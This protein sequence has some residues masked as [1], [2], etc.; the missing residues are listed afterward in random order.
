MSSAWKN[1]KILMLEKELRD[2]DVGLNV[3][4]CRVDILGT[5]LFIF[6][7]Q[8]EGLALYIILWCVTL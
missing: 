5:I 4:R 6:F 8:I 2:D 3:L 7:I 1:V